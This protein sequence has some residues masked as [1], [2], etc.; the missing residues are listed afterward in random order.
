MSDISI[1]ITY[2]INK[3]DELTVV[4]NAKEEQVPELLWDFIRAQMDKEPDN[5]KPEEREVYNIEITLNLDGDIF[6]S[7]SDT[8]NE[9]L[10]DGI[11]MDVAKRLE[12]RLAK[13]S[14]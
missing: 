9:G 10:R 6:R 3:P 7:T 4:S 11:I 2:P 12:A 8:G 5:R 1:S 13:P 14:S